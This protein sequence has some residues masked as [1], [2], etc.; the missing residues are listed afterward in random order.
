MRRIIKGAGSFSFWAG[1]RI[2][3]V[4]VSLASVVLV[5]VVWLAAC[6]VV[7]VP[8]GVAW[9]VAEKVAGWLL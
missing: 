4:C 7:L 1:K 5:M 8:V 6:L 3:T 9:T 2:A